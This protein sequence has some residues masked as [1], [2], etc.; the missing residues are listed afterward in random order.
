MVYLEGENVES[1]AMGDVMLKSYAWCMVKCTNW[2]YYITGSW[3]FPINWM[4]QCS[5]R[6]G[7]FGRKLPLRIG[8]AEYMRMTNRV[9]TIMWFRNLLT[10]I[11]YPQY[12]LIPRDALLA[13]YGY[14]VMLVWDVDI[15]WWQ[16]VSEPH[17]GFDFVI[18]ARVLR[19][20]QP[21]RYFAVEVAGLKMHRGASLCISI[22]LR[23]V[24]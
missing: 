10:A 13:C 17:D 23:V 4:W 1:T 8:Q 16:E 11:R 15:Q 6:L 22:R 5:W 19:L 12:K 7:R 20:A 9:K 18:H 3:R 21:Y 14:T 2:T 24:G